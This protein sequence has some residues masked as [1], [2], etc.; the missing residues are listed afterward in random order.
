MIDRMRAVAGALAGAVLVVLSA[1][2]CGKS[3]DVT[4]L[5]VRVD[6]DLTPGTDFD[7][8]V[9]MV[10]TSRGQK[11]FTFPVTAVG[12]LPVSV[13][14][15]PA[16]DRNEPLE[17]AVQ[18]QL[19]AL[20]EPVVGQNLTTAFVAGIPS[21]V[22][23]FLA[24]ACLGVPACP[25]AETCRRGACGPGQVDAVPYDAGVPPVDAA[26]GTPGAQGGHGGNGG[27]GEGNGGNGTAG[28][29]GG[30]GGRGGATG[31]NGGRGGAA[32]GGGGRG[33]IGG[34]SPPDAGAGG[35]SAPLD[36]GLDL[37]AD[38]PSDMSPTDTAP[39][40]MVT[41]PACMMATRPC[42]GASSC[43][44]GL[45]C[46]TTT[47]GQVCC[48]NY[49]A[50]CTLAGGEDCCGELE[51]VSNKCCLPVRRPCT[52]ASCC[53]GLVCGNNSLGKVC[54][55]NAGAHCT[56]TDGTECC[57]ALECVNNACR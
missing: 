14:L 51:C 17:I 25:P 54:C 27:N 7:A 11:T 57:G 34:A 30:N 3:G 24:R 9:V 41:P 22:D 32:G 21:V 28:A 35:G 26:G 29:A 10:R 43:C 50:G 13:A 56:R 49:N 36:A 20:R 23:V 37:P 31:G 12:T 5:V 40:D 39:P 45:T 33:G 4:S 1:G 48:G 6:S 19:A 8:V 53:S 15:L 2:G 18:A 46:G 52:D 47:L 16:Q 42:P 44:A 55:G 38:A